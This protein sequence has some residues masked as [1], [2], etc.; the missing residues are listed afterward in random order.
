MT[1]EIICIGPFD[2]ELRQFYEHPTGNYGVG[3]EVVLVVTRLFLIGEGSA[4]SRQFAEGLGISDPWDFSQHRLD[5]ARIDFA[6]LETIL[7][8]LEAWESQY[9]NDLEALRA[10]AA[11]R[12]DLYFMP[13]G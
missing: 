11:R 4:A 5:I 2:P 8:G 12:H 6:A 9:R 1:A 10:F 3:S 7:S 13:N